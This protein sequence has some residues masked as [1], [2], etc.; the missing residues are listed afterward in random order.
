MPAPIAPA[1]GR[2]AAV[3]RFSFCYRGARHDAR[4]YEAL[5]V[6]DEKASACR[7]EIRH[8]SSIADDLPPLSSGR[9]SAARLSKAVGL[10]GLIERMTR[11]DRSANVPGTLVS[12]AHLQDQRRPLRR[13]TVPKRSKARGPRERWPAVQGKMTRHPLART[14]A[15]LSYPEP[16]AL[17]LSRTP[18]L[19]ARTRSR[20]PVRRP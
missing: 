6:L 20:Y 9:L 18:A 5:I 2:G 15:T 14:A 7:I 13:K 3:T 10:L 12:I 8:A 17:A 1:S 19:R 4:L 16:L 11:H